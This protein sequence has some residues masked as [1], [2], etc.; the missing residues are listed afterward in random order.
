VSIEK[1]ILLCLLFCFCAGAPAWA[2]PAS[3]FSS[4][5]IQPDGT[6]IRLIQKGDESARW[7]ETPEGYTVV[8]NPGSGYW[9]Y[10]L[11]DMRSIDLAPSG[12]VVIADIPPS[13]RI[14][15]H[16]KPMRFHPDTD[17]RGSARAPASPFPF[18]AQQ[19]DGKTI[20]LVQKGDEKLHWTETKDGYSVVQNPK[21]GFW[22]YA[23]RRLVV[24]L[25]PSEIPYVPDEAPPE[26]WPLHLKP[27]PRIGY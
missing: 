3:P 7:T 15:K 14:R 5:A 22:E 26:G 9:E 10:A 12:T 21:S 11:K 6:K 2:V 20:T 23:V 1:G 19:P 4:D 18:Q 17:A 13:P 24:V 25:A 16:L 8:K 27:S